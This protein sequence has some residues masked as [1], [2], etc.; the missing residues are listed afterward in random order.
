MLR[1]SQLG[2]LT[3]SL[4]FSWATFAQ[5]GLSPNVQELLTKAKAGDREAQFHV[6]A[7]YDYG[8]G[9][10]HDGKEALKWYLAS[11]EQGFAEAQNSV[12]SG[13]QAEKRYAE[14][15]PWYE[16]AAAQ[17]HAL[18]TN[19]LAYLYDLGLGVPQDRMKGFDLY[20]KAANLGWAEA[21]WNLTN[22]Y[23]AGQ[24]G[25]PDMIMACIWALR[26]KKYATPNETRLLAYVER[27]MPRLERMLST[28]QFVSCKQQSESWSPSVA[29]TSSKP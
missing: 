21:M 24:I 10:P 2:A 5:E 18:A 27:V 15:L 6:G 8:R 14:A 19:N 28:E 3:F 9:A 13:L 16:K 22:M 11:A 23:G 26:A 20:T 1:P 17:G 29:L 4:L 25:K 7:A 12:G